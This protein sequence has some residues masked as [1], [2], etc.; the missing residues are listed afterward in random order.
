KYFHVAV[1]VALGIFSRV[2]PYERLPEGLTC[3]KADNTVADWYRALREALDMPAARFDLLRRR[4][5]AH[6]RETF[7]APAH[8]HLHQPSS[9]AR[10]RRR[11]P[12][13]PRG[14]PRPPPPHP[15][16]PAPPPPPPP[17]SPPRPPPPPP[18]PPPSPPPPPPPAS[19]ASPRSSSSAAASS[20]R[21][22]AL[23]C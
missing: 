22:P 18:P 12:R 15:P 11:T 21:P 2:P 3:L 8:L 9:P 16:P 13:A 14:P 10:P 4:T 6:V 23:G 19:T 17:S 7:T 5:L 20:T 1:A